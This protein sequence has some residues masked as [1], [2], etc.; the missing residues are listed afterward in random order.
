MHKICNNIYHNAHCST[1]PYAHSLLN[2]LRKY[3]SL[4]WYLCGGLWMTSHGN[5]TFQTHNNPSVSHSLARFESQEIMKTKRNLSKEYISNHDNG[6]FENC[7]TILL[8]AYF[9][10]LLCSTFEFWVMSFPHFSRLVF[11][12]RRI[13]YNFLVAHSVFFIIMCDAKHY[14]RAKRCVIHRK[15]NRLF[16]LLHFNGTTFHRKWNKRRLKMVKT[17]FVCS[18]FSSVSVVVFFSSWLVIEYFFSVGIL[19]GFHLF[20]GMT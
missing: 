4:F 20:M 2:C 13:E 18:F 3:V 8:F 15:A 6:T 16:D 12:C 9:Y 14:W 5:R 7:K 19:A 1:E 17:F 10:M 11:V